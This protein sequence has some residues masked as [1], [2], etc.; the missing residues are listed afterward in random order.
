MPRACCDRVHIYVTHAQTSFTKVMSLEI[1]MFHVK[2]D[3]Q[4]L[5]LLKQWALHKFCCVVLALGKVQTSP[6]ITLINIA[7]RIQQVAE[8]DINIGTH[9]DIA[10][11]DTASFR[12][13]NT[14]LE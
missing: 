8:C 7:K 6:S 13:M 10:L 12:K 14:F 9:H 11:A 2:C 5:L 3:L 1:Q 4:D